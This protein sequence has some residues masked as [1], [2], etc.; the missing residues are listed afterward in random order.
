MSMIHL[1][2]TFIGFGLLTLVATFFMAVS[3]E[4]RPP[5][6]RPE[7]VFA[8]DMDR[9]FIKEK[10]VIYQDSDPK[11]YL[12]VGKETYRLAAYAPEFMA[13]LHFYFKDIL[14]ERTTMAIFSAGT[15][16]RN[17]GVV[18]GWRL[19]QDLHFS[20][21]ITMIKSFHDLTLLKDL[22][23]NVRKEAGHAYIKS[24]AGQEHVQF[25]ELFTKDLNIFGRSLNQVIIFED[26]YNAVPLSQAENLLLVARPDIFEEK[27]NRDQRYSSAHWVADG[28]RNPVQIA[29]ARYRLVRAIGVL[30]SAGELYRH[31]LYASVPQALSA[32]QWSK[33]GQY[34]TDA[35]NKKPVYDE[36]MRILQLVYNKYLAKGNPELVRD[37]SYFTVQ[38]V[39]AR[40]QDCDDT[41]TTQRGALPWDKQ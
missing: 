22:P 12:K 15:S 34:R 21:V 5:G 29:R 24:Q 41:L 30:S 36:G 17:T 3:A 28:K 9:L 23:L 20:D 7:Y 39:R 4:A 25:F 1:R 37:L 31:G 2:R 8:L 14:Q 10:A 38:P 27:L 26:N 33:D 18:N 6:G 32:M 16:D 11:E 35:M 19:S 13:A 40:T